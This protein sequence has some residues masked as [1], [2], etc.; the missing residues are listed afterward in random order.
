MFRREL[1]AAWQS[2]ASSLES[3]TERG[4]DVVVASRLLAMIAGAFDV[5]ESDSHRL[6]PDDTLWELYRHYYPRRSGWRGW[7][8]SIRPDELELE[9][10]LRDL[11]RVSPSFVAANLHE[12]VS[13]GD[14]VLLLERRDSN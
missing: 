5:S 8:D 14:L 2:R 1:P 12:A 10:L 4:Y 6:R 3:W 7:Y 13:L 11:Q 9:T